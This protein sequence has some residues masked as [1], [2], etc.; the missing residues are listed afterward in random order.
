MLIVLMLLVKLFL[1][2]NRETFVLEK[3]AM[4]VVVIVVV[5]V[6]V[7]YIGWK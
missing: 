3:K 2:V 1:K 5:A 6:V 4:V 7:A